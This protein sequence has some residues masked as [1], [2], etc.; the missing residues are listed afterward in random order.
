V[1]VFLP[2]WWIAK[3]APQGAWDSD[4]LRFSTPHCLKN[5]TRSAVTE[6]T[7][8]LDE[9]IL[10]HSEVRVIGYISAVEMP[11]NNPLEQVLVE[12]RQ[13]LSIMGKDAADALPEHRSYDHSIDLK[14]G[15][16]LP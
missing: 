11:A 16:N 1:D 14:L 12:F 9:S 6:F 5:C 10:S 7:L 3:H 4:E 2:Y 15:K 8:D 13:F